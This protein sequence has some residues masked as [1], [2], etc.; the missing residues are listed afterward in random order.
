MCVVICDV[1]LFGVMFDVIVVICV[2]M[3][4]VI[5]VVI[6]VVMC[7]VMCIDTFVANCRHGANTHTQSQSYQDLVY[8]QNLAKINQH[9]QHRSN[10]NSNGDT[11]SRI[12][13]MVLTRTHTIRIL[14]IQVA[15]GPGSYNLLLL[16][17]VCLMWGWRCLLLCVLLF[18]CYLVCY[19]CC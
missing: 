11:L 10:R 2:V 8:T 18:V 15:R 17:L 5:A 12:V 3:V 19:C 9:Q 14:T 13:A 16:L 1:L 4:V 7:V 6:C